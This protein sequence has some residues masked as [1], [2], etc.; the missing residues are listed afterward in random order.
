MQHL[1]FNKLTAVEHISLKKR[2]KEE[3]NAVNLILLI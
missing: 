2:K 1:Y 3:K